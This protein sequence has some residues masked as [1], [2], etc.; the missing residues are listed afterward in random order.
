MY[1]I[2]VVTIQRDTTQKYHAPAVFPKL[3]GCKAE[4]LTFKHQY[5]NFSEALK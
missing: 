2:D 4:D 3:A 1:L 5:P